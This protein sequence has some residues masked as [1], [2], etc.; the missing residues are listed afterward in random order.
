MTAN[1][2]T[3][4]QTLHEFV[5]L[6]RNRLSPEIWDYLIGGTETETT[7]KRNRRALDSIAFRPRVLRD[8]SEVDGRAR[9]LDIPLRLP[10]AIAPV[11]SLESFH[12]EGGVTA[13][14]AAA[15]FG[16]ISIHSSV[17]KP[18]IETIGTAAADGATIYQLYVRGDDAFVDAHARRAVEAGCRAF[19]ITV[20][21]QMYSRR[22]RDIARRFVKPWRRDATGIDRQA[23]FNWNNVR[24]FKDRHD[25]PLILKGIATAEDAEM[26]CAHGVDVVYV[27][28]HGGRQLDHGRGALDVLPEVV[29]AVAGRAAVAIDGGF[30]RGT[31]IVKAIALGADLVGLGRLACIGMAAGGVDGV[32]RMFE[33]LEDEVRICLGLLGVTGF[34]GIEASHLIRAE[35]VDAAHVFSAFPLLN[36]DDP[37]Y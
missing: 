4:F 13:A 35:P 27:S 2:A 31:D 12:P 24:R 37:G 36:L 23:A 5:K 25:I 32:V 15:R 14:R 22:E 30:V 28:N 29:A 18:D 7:L 10:I 19:C 6:A 3:E 11:G 33:I 20:D 26:A 1:P 9:F 16:C 17:S 34:D 21:S 8:V